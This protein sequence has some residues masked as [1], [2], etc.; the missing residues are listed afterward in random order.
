MIT[1]ENVFFGLALGSSLLLALQLILTLTGLGGGEADA[2]DAPDVGADLPDDAGLGV[3][4]TRSIVAFFVGFG[5]SGTLS[6]RSGLGLFPATVAALVVGGVFLFT[7]FYLMRWAHS[8]AESGNVDL[9]NAVGQSGSVYL[10]I[11]G[12]GKGNGLI[13]VNVQG[14]LREV[15]AITD[16]QGAFATGA[17]VRVVRMVDDSTALV[18]GVQSSGNG[19]DKP[20]SA[21]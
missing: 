8:L 7:I 18:R 3:F 14:R 1:P 17:R 4:S 15:T 16:E 6:M 12:A 13:Q 21:Q 9:A 2:V 11:P 5:W 10:P 19:S 20:Q